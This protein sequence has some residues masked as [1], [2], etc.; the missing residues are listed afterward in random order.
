MRLRA[1]AKTSMES[2][3]SAA[4]PGG[5]ARFRSSRFACWES[6]RWSGPASL[7]GVRVIA[8]VALRGPVGDGVGRHPPAR[9]RAYISETS[10]D[11]NAIAHAAQGCFYSGMTLMRSKILAY[12]YL[13][14]RIRRSCLNTLTGLIRCMSTAPVRDANKGQPY[15]AAKSVKTKNGCATAP[16]RYRNFS[17][18]LSA[19]NRRAPS[20]SGT[21]SPV[22]WMRSLSRNGWNKIPLDFEGHHKKVVDQPKP[23]TKPCHKEK[24]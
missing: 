4:S 11:L 20:V 17:A 5:G 12:T 13:L 1:A 19:N 23:P 24:P 2:M 14:P 3:K 18:V 21:E 6:T 22:E 7:A 16:E 9:N 10:L 8:R 15:H